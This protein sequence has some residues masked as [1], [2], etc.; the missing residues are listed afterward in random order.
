MVLQAAHETSAG[1]RRGL[2]LDRPAQVFLGI[3]LLAHQQ[4]VEQIVEECR[5]DWV[6]AARGDVAQFERGCRARYADGQRIGFV[7]YDAAAPADAPHPGK[8]PAPKLPGKGAG[9]GAPPPLPGA[10]KGAPPPPPGAGK[11]A[12]P[13]Q[14]G[15][16]GPPP[17]GKGV[18]PPKGVGNE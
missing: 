12:P 17:P 2:Q 18:P 6:S 5:V 16:G 13:P 3:D 8:G 4:R 15:K 10:G 14:P 9:K 11:G 1:P 7:A